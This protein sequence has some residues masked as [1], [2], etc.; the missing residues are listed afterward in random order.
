MRSW[1]NVDV[2]EVISDGFGGFDASSSGLIAGRPSLSF[3]NAMR[4]SRNRKETWNVLSNVYIMLVG[5][6]TNWKYGIGRPP[7]FLYS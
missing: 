7:F 6:I 4:P 3:T 5:S 2:K 1:L